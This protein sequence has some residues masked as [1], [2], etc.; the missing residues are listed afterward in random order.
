MIRRAAIVTAATLALGLVSA[1]AQ[2]A[3]DSVLRRETNGC[4]VIKPAQFAICLD[5]F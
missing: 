4:I 3:S 5:R 1:P 2:A